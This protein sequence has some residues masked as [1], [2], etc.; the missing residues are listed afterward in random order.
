MKRL[1]DDAQLQCTQGSKMSSLTIPPTN[2]G[3][4]SERTIVSRTKAVHLHRLRGS[5]TRRT[6]TF[7]AITLVCTACRSRPPP[8][9]LVQTAYTSTAA[10]SPNV[11]SEN[12]S[13]PP[14]RQL[15][16]IS[17]TVVRTTRPSLRVDANGQAAVAVELCRSRACDALERVPVATNGQVTLTKDLEPGLWYW[18]VAPS[19]SATVGPV[20]YFVV[21]S[22]QGH[23]APSLRGVDVDGDAFADLVLGGGLLRGNRGLP[24]AFE[25]INANLCNA[26]PALQGPPGGCHDWT[27]IRPLGDV[28]GDGFGDVALNGMLLR[29]SV[30]GFRPEWDARS[31]SVDGLCDATSAGDTNGDGY[32]DILLNRSIRL[33]SPTGFEKRMDSPAL[34]S[35]DEIL[36]AGDMD[37]DGYDDLFIVDRTKLSVALLRGSS[38]GFISA[39]TFGLPGSQARDRDNSHFHVASADA[40]GDGAPDAVVL[41]VAPK[42]GHREAVVTT[43]LG[44]PGMSPAHAATRRVTWTEGAMNKPSYDGLVVADIDG[45]GYDDIIVGLE[46]AK[47]DF[48][49][50][51]GGA[52]SIHLD[53]F[54]SPRLEEDGSVLSVSTV[55]DVDGNGCDD[56]LV[57]GKSVA[58]PDATDAHLFLGDRTGVHSSPIL[59]TQSR[60]DRVPRISE[61]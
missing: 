11:P 35:A 16:P 31:C 53:P 39:G 13:L 34:A 1:V 50:I 20:W 23:A 15:S 32:P 19:K 2:I 47:S 3:L 38:N 7:L 44:G 18:R 57:V 5:V 37:R 43:Y 36:R 24:S 21:H 8:S 14:P 58:D 27:T 22:G 10:P 56:V 48:R 42:G 33:G 26:P 54:R 29:G 6:T 49:L 9:D 59:L 55:G 25:P 45:N 4:V 30:N 12:V 60:F 52:D 61:R 41:S 28:D 40:N 17:G 46:S 51:R